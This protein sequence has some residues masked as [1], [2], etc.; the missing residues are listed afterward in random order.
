MYVQ[1]TDTSK[2][3]IF[4]DETDPANWITII[5]NEMTLGTTDTDSC[6]AEVVTIETRDDFYDVV[7]DTL[8]VKV[9]MT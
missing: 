6:S 1:F 9:D 2:E 5:V 3:V 7:S 4:P 8:F